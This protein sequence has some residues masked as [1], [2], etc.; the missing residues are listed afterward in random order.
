M[1]IYE[2]P[3]LLCLLLISYVLCSTSFV[4][5]SICLS[6]FTYSRKTKFQVQFCLTNV[7]LLTR[8]LFE[9]LYHHF[10][11]PKKKKIHVPFFWKNDPDDPVIS[12]CVAEQKTVILDNLN[13]HKYSRIAIFFIRHIQKYY[14][15]RH[16]FLFSLL[17]ADLCYYRLYEW[18]N[19]KV[20][21]VYVSWGWRRIDR[22]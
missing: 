2:L 9:Y 16:N 13:E 8:L 18:S 5:C 3:W 21:W 1:A 6:L 19:K 7:S 11:P 4:W 14:I 15:I 22:P 17:P 20:K 10:L 12:S